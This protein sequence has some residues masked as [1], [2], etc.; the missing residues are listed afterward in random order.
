MDRRTL[1]GITPYVSLRGMNMRKSMMIIILAV[2]VL[3][4][5]SCFHFAGAAQP[6]ASGQEETDSPVSDDTVEQQEERQ[7]LK[8]KTIKTADNT[9]NNV[10]GNELGRIPEELELIP[11]NYYEPAEHPGTLGKLT[12]Q[13]WESFTYEEHSQAL[14][15]EAWVYLPYG[16]SEDH[17]YNI[18][19]LS[20]GGW[21][22]ET[23]IMGT[24]EEPA[25]FKHIIDHSI[26]DR[27]M[28]PMILVM[29][30][31]NNT[32]PQDSWDY[33]LALQLTDQFHN[34]LVNDII[35]AVE[36][37]YS[38]YAEDTSAE[39][40]RASRDHRGFG[41][42]SMGSVNTWCTF[43]YA[44]DC[45]RY[46][47]PMS[48]NYTTDG[49]FMAQLVKSQGFDADDFFIYSMSGPDDFAY[50]GIKAQIQAMAKEGM[51]TYGDTEDAGNL[52]WREMDGFSH[53][54]EASNL[55]TYNGLQFFWN[56]EHEDGGK[57]CQI[58]VTYT[59]DSLIS[60]VIADPAFGDYGRL[61]FPA[62]TG[63]YRGNQLNNLSLTWYGALDPDK[64]VEIINTL[65]NRAA[66]GEQV[67][68]DIYTDEEKVAD[69]DKE[70]TGLFFFR[71]NPGER[72]A[73]CNAGGGFAFVG[74]MHDSFPHALEISKKGYN[75]FALI[76]RPG[77]QTAC[78]DLARAIAFIFDHAE[79]LEIDTSDYSL[80]G[81]SA[82][83]RMAAWLGS[84][85]TENFGEESY[86]RPAAVIM[87]YTGLS[88]VYGNEPPT[89]NCVGTS[90]GIASYRTMQARIDA[91]KKNGTDAEIEVF[92]GLSHGFG[93][94]TGT[95]AEGW[96]DRAVAFWER[97][98]K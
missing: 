11:P 94:G 41:G 21:S 87:Q 22:N 16:Y 96:L 93:L 29:V 73:V 48:G 26:E 12:Y 2:V 78:E 88:E 15:K 71:G 40:I 60:D 83:A 91:I 3:L 80:W 13:T 67:F 52:A 85:G 63:Y 4:P 33:S 24:A 86:P 58:P 43:R 18:F 74:A 97:N 14:T 6:G 68:F 51:F 72:F 5:A 84:I 77:A 28:Q 19:Y 90:D 46:F 47:M 30:T 57:I 76:Y 42:F 53:G 36:S 34:E 70:D 35:P 20:H 23:T 59:G 31:Y 54:R 44:L 27:K 7:D 62:D 66:D 8:E 56:G 95:A 50:S 49:S 45:F 82:G 98:M 55:Y 65:Q 75:T 17:Q 79:E 89:Y 9:M 25:D 64:T 10:A 92:Q 61:L 39:G 32:D 69:P 38:T 81:G 37:K 1:P